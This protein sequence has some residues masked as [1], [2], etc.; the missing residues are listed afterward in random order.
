MGQSKVS[1][2]FVSGPVPV[3]VMSMPPTNPLL[4]SDTVDS[5]TVQALWAGLPVVTVSGGDA[6]DTAPVAS[7]AST[8]TVY[9]VPGLR[10]PAVNVVPDVSPHCS[11]VVP[12]WRWTSYFTTPGTDGQV[13]VAVRSVVE[14]VGCPG[15]AGSWAVRAGCRTSVVSES[16]GS[17]RLVALPSV[18]VVTPVAPLVN[19]CTVG[20]AAEGV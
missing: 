18:D 6:H 1:V 7:R 11:L 4:Q 3:F 14:P 16:G 2:Q 19:V 15:A 13:I 9:L 20:A 8:L 10:F 17:V 12:S 5:R